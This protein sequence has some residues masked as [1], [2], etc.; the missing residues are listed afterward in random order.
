MISWM[1]SSIKNILSFILTISV[2]EYESYG[3]EERVPVKLVLRIVLQGKPSQEVAS[4]DSHQNH[5]HES[6][7]LKFQWLIAYKAQIVLFCYRAL[8]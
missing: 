5:C 7:H 3:H 8:R 1:I 6:R 4:P 2:K